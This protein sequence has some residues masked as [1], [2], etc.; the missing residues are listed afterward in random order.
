M[1][2]LD[3]GKYTYSALLVRVPL[4]YNYSGAND[5]QDFCA[6][7]NVTELPLDGKNSHPL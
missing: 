1:A 2:D 6:N 7:G 3:I 5:P 4:T